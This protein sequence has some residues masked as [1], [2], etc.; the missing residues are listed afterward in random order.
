MTNL[1]LIP[2]VPHKVLAEEI[3]WQELPSVILPCFRAAFLRCYLLTVEV[4]KTVLK[5]RKSF[6]K[7]S[8]E[9]IKTYL[10]FQTKSD[11]R[12]KEASVQTTAVLP[13]LGKIKGTPTDSSQTRTGPH[14]LKSVAKSPP[15]AKKP[16]FI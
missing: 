11:A 7:F 10:T 4:T 5:I 3:Y 14:P 9:V 8:L 2:K 13:A 12:V 16:D 6:G 15:D 1:L